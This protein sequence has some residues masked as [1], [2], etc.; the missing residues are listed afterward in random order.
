LTCVDSRF[1]DWATSL[2]REISEQIEN[3]IKD[4]L[5]AELDALVAHL[6]GLSENQLRYIYENFQRG[7]ILSD[8]LEKALGY[9]K[10]INTS[11]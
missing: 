1:K 5:L 2:G 3:E 4:E 6:F 8:R 9:L 11:G 10:E 7:T